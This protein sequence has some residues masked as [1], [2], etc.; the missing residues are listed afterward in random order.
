MTLRCLMC[1]GVARGFHEFHP[2]PMCHAC[3]TRLRDALRADGVE[4]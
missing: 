1:K 4:I 2:C 3:V